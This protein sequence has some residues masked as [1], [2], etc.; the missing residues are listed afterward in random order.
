[1]LWI[2]GSVVMVMSK[3]PVRILG[4]F[5]DFLEEFGQLICF[6]VAGF[7]HS[8]TGRGAVGDD[9]VRLP[10]APIQIFPGLSVFLIGGQFLLPP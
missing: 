1:M 10:T 8:R 5:F 6:V 3:Q 9:V 2:N 4:F 7:H